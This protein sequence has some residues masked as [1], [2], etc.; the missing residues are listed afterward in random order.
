MG[1]DITLN[2]A[3]LFRACGWCCRAWIIP[4]NAPADIGDGNS[5]DTGSF[6]EVEPLV[7]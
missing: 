7:L 3:L 1:G 6:P 4:M 5:S 2:V